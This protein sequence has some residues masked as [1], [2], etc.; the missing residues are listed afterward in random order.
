MA[1]VEQR[2][3]DVYG[4]T[5]DVKHYKILVMENDDTIID[6]ELDLCPRA[7]DRFRNWLARGT[8]PPKATMEEG[9]HDNK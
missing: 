1:L 5:K 3:C 4:T 2:V 9:T 7:F 8:A 6:Q